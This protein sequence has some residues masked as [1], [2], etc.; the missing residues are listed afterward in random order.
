MRVAI[1]DAGAVGSQ[2]AARLARSGVRVGLIARG[3]HLQAIREAG[4]TL[5][6]AEERVTVAVEATDNATEL[7]VQDVAIIAVKGTQIAVAAED[8][9]P[10][11][12][13]RTRLV[14][15]MN[16]LPWWF[17]EGM[18]D[19]VRSA[20][21]GRLDS[22]G[23]VAKLSPLENVIWGVV[24]SGGAVVSPG[25][26]RNTTPQVNR[27]TLGYPDDRTD[28]EIAYIAGLL[29][30]A[31]YDATAARNI[32]EAIWAKLLTNV[33]QAM[34]ATITNRNHLQVTS[35]PD[36]RA[37]IIE[38]MHELLTIGEA[39][40]LRIA[41][42]PVAMTDPSRFGAHVPSFLQD[43]RAGRSL[44]LD[45]TILAVRDIARAL[46]LPAPHLATIAAIVAA[47]STDAARRGDG[48]LGPC[49]AAE[50]QPQQREAD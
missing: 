20:L 35:D 28:A 1:F 11:V 6:A 41:A 7:G 46:G 22:S 21:A 38:V 14:F 24:T 39:I 34:V 42:D 8:I 43:L 2:I 4:L 44:E 17:A 36:T 33:A 32:R 31:G 9:R 50:L 5:L 40:G 26:V 15:A 30:R 3:A 29:G 49:A 25:V 27:I 12:G 47:Q 16:G 19:A 37:V 23:R 13:E 45:S 18:S 10:L 48:P